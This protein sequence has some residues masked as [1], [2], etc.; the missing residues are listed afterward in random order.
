MSNR[1]LEKLAD[2]IGVARTAAKLTRGL[3]RGTRRTAISTAK[4]TGSVV[5]NLHAPHVSGSD[6]VHNVNPSAAVSHA[7]GA[8]GKF[9]QG[10]VGKEERAQ[11]L[12]SGL[13]KV[14]GHG[15]FSAHPQAV[16][17]VAHRNAPVHP[18]ETA[19]GGKQE[20][21]PRRQTMTAAEAAAP[22]VSSPKPAVI[23]EQANRR[24]PAR[25]T[26]QT[27]AAGGRKLGPKAQET[28]AKIRMK[29][30][31]SVNPVTPHGHAHTNSSVH[32]SETA[33]GHKPTEIHVRRPDF[34]AGPKRTPERITQQSAESALPGKRQPMRLT[35]DGLTDRTAP[36][37]FKAEGGKRIPARLTQDHPVPHTAD[38]RREPRRLVQHEEF[39]SEG[40][41]IP[42]RLTQDGA[43]HPADLKAPAGN[44]KPLVEHENFKAGPK[45]MPNRLTQDHP[46]PHAT[47]ARREPRRLVQS[48]PARE[49][50]KAGPKRMPNRLTQDN[51]VPHTVDERRKPGRLVQVD[52]IHKATEQVAHTAT[53]TRVEQPNVTHVSA[54][55]KIE[56]AQPA[57]KQPFSFNKKHLA[58]A[59]AIGVGGL[60]LGHMMSRDK[61]EDE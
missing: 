19:V 28:L 20:A 56:K 11:R 51:T 42:G 47:E 40:K 44:T 37:P 17:G 33:L 52:D 39:K 57:N 24:N 49:E 55:P 15:G 50:F 18:S 7:T 21:M 2:T 10:L 25:L 6:F 26:Q 54:E 43:M 38:P 34:E 32:P 59:G 9:N 27:E 60:T 53:G 23:H 5:H 13:N 31:Y 41:R 48:E 14:D 46:V 29:A 58:A 30:D 3:F 45:R 16:E 61:K 36:A 12:A 1:Y 4:A 35:Q 8:T 22:H